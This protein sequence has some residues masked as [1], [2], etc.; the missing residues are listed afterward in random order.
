MRLEEITSKYEHPIIGIIGATSPLQG[1]DS[2]EARKLGYRLRGLVEKRGSLFT[3]G[4]SGVGVDTYRGIVDYCLERRVSDKFF[5]LFPDIEPEPDKEYFRLAEQTNEGILKLERAGKNMEERRT[6]VG[7]VA[8]LLIVVNG[9]E[10]TID[11][12]IRGLLLEKPIICLQ[13]SGGAAEIMAKLKRGEIN[14]P[15]LSIN[16]GLIEAF[17]STDEIINYLSNINLYKLNENE[18]LK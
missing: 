10:G 1:Y 18:E 16:L 17:T 11:E 12:A 8:D 9:A 4:V 15:N 13:N 6:Y 3:G 5:I 14:M 7:A 2:Q